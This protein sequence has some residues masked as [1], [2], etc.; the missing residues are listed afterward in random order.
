MTRN[1]R[2][3]VLLCGA[4]MLAVLAGA[5]LTASAQS[6]TTQAPG[7]KFEENQ[8]GPIAEGTQTRTRAQERLLKQEP[9][10]TQAGELIRERIR[11]RIRVARDVS[12]D[13]QAA[14]QANLGAL[15]RAGVT[16][17]ALETVF[18]GYGKARPISV[19]TML[20]L[21]TRLAT[22]GQDGLPTEPVLAKV[23]EALMKGVSDSGLARVCERAENHVRAA[24]QI[25]TRAQADG[26]APAGEALR[27]RQMIREMAQ[28]MWRGTDPDE[29]EALRLR[30]RDRLRAK[31]GS[32]ADLVAAT[33]TATRLRE[34]GVDA[35]RAMRVAGEAL[36]AGYGAPELRKFQYMLVYRHRENREVHG[37][38]DDFEHCLRTGMDSAHMYQYM[39]QHHWMGPADVQGPGV[40][41]PIDDQGRGAG[42]P[43]IGAEIGS[44]TGLESG[45]D[46]DLK[47]DGNK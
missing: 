29:I 9:T 1:R 12:Q 4:V 8:A 38:V 34:E 11:E 27:E 25:M 33:E 20:R 2:F 41:Q 35:K 19:P 17:P 28:Q 43:G 42:A 32:V 23:Q 45:T 10:Q 3:I 22:M 46:G 24:K 39:M 31:G 37:L 16:D 44:G 18:P 15:V 26:A 7:P 14:M 36:Q 6:E 13:D 40:S 47:G 30:T 21:Q 5:S